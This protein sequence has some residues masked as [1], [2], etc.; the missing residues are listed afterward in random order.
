M[1]VLPP[2]IL[3][4]LTFFVKVAVLILLFLYV[5][6]SLIVVRQV[7]LMAR[8]LITPVSPIVKAISIVN[9]GFAVGFLILAFGIL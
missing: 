5:I 9:A 6:F 4:N 2:S 7:D 3:F 8:T 1:E